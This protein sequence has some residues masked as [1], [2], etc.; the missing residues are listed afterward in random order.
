[1]LN[2]DFDVAVWSE[3]VVRLQDDATPNSYGMVSRKNGLLAL[4]ECTAHG[5]GLPGQG[6]KN[7]GVRG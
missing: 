2:S 6:A 7:S 3:A 5:R 1:M 4:E